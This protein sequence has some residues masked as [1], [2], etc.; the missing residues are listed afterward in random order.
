[1]N[2]DAASGASPA[3]PLAAPAE[4][5]ELSGRL[6]LYIAKSTP[7]SMR[8][9]NNLSTALQEL[10]SEGRTFDLE[11]VDVFSHPKRAVTDGVIVTPTLIGLSHN[12]RTLIMGDLSNSIQLKLFLGNLQQSPHADRS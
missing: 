5:K 12:Q 7:N 4:G 9:E 8:A 3:G 1:M 11:I 6:R 2:D 10:G